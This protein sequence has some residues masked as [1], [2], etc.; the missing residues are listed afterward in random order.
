[1]II[2][3]GADLICLDFGKLKDSCA[4]SGDGIVFYYSP[5][6][7]ASL[8]LKESR[9]CLAEEHWNAH[10][11]Q[12]AIRSFCQLP[13]ATI[14]LYVSIAFRFFKI[15]F[16][17]C[18]TFGTPSGYTTQIGS[19]AKESFKKNLR[20]NKD[21]KYCLLSKDVTEVKVFHPGYQNHSLHNLHS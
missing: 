7:R 2:Y 3:A 11:I 6:L 1:M 12:C 14:K 17:N 19:K 15:P 18:I 16:F 20:T 21:V 4:K 13:S 9:A 10:R 8:T 5:V